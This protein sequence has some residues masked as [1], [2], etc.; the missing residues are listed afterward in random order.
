MKIIISLYFIGLL[1]PFISCNKI[2][3]PTSISDK[4]KQEIIDR[5]TK[6]WEYS[7]TKELDKLKEILA[8]DYVG[9]FGRKTM[10]EADVIKSLQKATLKSY[11][12]MNVRIKPITNDVAIMYYIANQN[13][14]SEDGIPWVPKV[15]AA[16]TYVKRNGIWYGVFYQETV[17]D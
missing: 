7:K 12:L 14:V 10:N 1:F 4:D 16:A 13:G 9:F 17:L 3:S 8:D 11:E 2:N 5:E 15:A 6:T